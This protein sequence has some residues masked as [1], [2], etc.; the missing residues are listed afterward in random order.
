MLTQVIFKKYYILKKWRILEQLQ[1]TQE[2]KKNKVDM[3]PFY[4][5]LIKVVRNKKTL[6][7]VNSAQ[8]IF[9]DL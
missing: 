1:E 9:S 4:K 2:K 6:G 3:K 5:T 8:Y 7:S